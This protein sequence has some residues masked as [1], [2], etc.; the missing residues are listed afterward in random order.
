VLMSLPNAGS[1]LGHY[2][3]TVES[4]EGPQQKLIV[5]RLAEVPD[6]DTFATK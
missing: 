4:A 1:R 2:F 5:I 3:H 6:S